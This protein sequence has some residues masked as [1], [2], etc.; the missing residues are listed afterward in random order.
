MNI[1]DFSQ[2]TILTGKQYGTTI[3]IELD[4]SDTSIDEVMDG[5][6]TIVMGLGYLD[7]TVNEWIKDKCKDIYDDEHQIVKDAFAEDWFDVFNDKEDYEGQFRDW[8]NETPTE[9]DL[10]TECWCGSRE[11]CD[12]ISDP[13]DNDEYSDFVDSNWDEE[14]MDVI[15]QNGNEGTHYGLA[16][17]EDIEECELNDKP[18]FDW[19]DDVDIIW[20]DEN[21]FDE[22]N[23]FDDYGMRKIPNDKLKAAAQRYSEEVKAK[24]KPVRL[25]K[26]KVVRGKIKDLKNGKT[27]D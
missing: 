12:C 4:H 6:L 1:K 21:E 10:P 11:R 27:K 8:E 18:H 17:D 3:T 22:S 23:E 26:S 20:F 7:T 24:H 15:G 13:N 25:D 9:E 14:R 16:T 5:M 2:P 19:N